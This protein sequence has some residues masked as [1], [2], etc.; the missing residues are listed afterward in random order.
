MTD[1]HG[2][3][4]PREEAQA[5]LGG[6][7][8]AR[9]LEPS[10]PTVTQ[11]PYADDPVDPAGAAVVSPVASGQLTWDAWADANP[12]HD[13]FLAARW[14]GRFPRL[15][16]PPDTLTATREALHALT[17]H[18][19]TPARFAANGK[20]AMRYTAGGFGTPFFGDDEQLRVVGTRLVRQRGGS[21]EATPI[22]TLAE[23]AAFALDGP[24]SLAWVEALTLH[25]PP[26]PV[27]H[28]Q[29]LEVD[30]EAAAFLADWFGFAWSI[31]EELRADAAS[32]EASRP[33]LWPEHFDPAIEVLP[34][35]QRA[36]YGF[37]PGDGGIPEPYIYVSVWYPDD[38]LA[39]TDA[40]LWNAED[41]RG[42]ALRLSEF[43]D[44]E[45]QRDHVL[46]WL[47]TRREALAH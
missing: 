27:P 28:D 45:D 1:L 46:R 14:L 32:T 12:G 9:V 16:S 31:L 7:L 2:A 11:D 23:A 29:A 43:A 36:S 41:F 44:L 37:S 21:A 24:P 35:K 15:G 25:D 40:S 39:G 42:G 4:D 8:E 10:P 34:D 38:A 22:T 19:L 26:Q 30:A 6:D 47:R 13:D 20:I 17:T 18:V 33:Q 5:L 3:R